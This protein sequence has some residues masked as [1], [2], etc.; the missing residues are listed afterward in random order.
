MLENYCAFQSFKCGLLLVHCLVRTFSVVLSSLFCILCIPNRLPG[1]TH[2]TF[3][4]RYDQQ[5]KTH[6][7]NVAVDEAI[8]A[9]ERERE[10]Y[11]RRLVRRPP[12]WG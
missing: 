5:S 4:L 1:D 12:A 3:G 8:C 10:S 7:K 11:A 9:E 2:W 6:S